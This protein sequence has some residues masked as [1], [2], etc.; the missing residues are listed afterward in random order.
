MALLLDT[1]IWLWGLLEPHR[2]TEQ[3]K[4]ALAAE[5]TALR[6]SPISL[7]ET[8][9]LAERGR[10]TLDRDPSDWLDKAMK[11][12]P[13]MEAP[14]TFD[15]AAASRNIALDHQDPA[16]RF[17]VATA[18]I[19]DLRLVTADLRLLRCQEIMVLPNH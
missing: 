9:M 13:V 19:F 12:S 1:H 4:Q 17:I 6:L 11:A 14:I 5:T 7:W 18:K 10:I 15:V 8:L 2:L 3:V 16:D